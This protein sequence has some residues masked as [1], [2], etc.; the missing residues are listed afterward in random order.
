MSK[1]R[2][3]RDRERT[4]AG[5]DWTEK[6]SVMQYSSEM[7]MDIR[8]TLVKVL[9]EESLNFH[10]EWLEDGSVVFSTASSCGAY[11]VTVERNAKSWKDLAA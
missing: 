10:L 1:T 7:P 11:K 3:Y 9:N 8:E 4:G 5:M 2:D 6:E